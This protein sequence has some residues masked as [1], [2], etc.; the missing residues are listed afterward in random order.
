MIECLFAK[1][2]PTADEPHPL[3]IVERNWTLNQSLHVLAT[4]SDLRDDNVHCRSWLCHFSTS[5]SC[6]DDT[7]VLSKTEEDNIRV[8][9]SM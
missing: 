1:F 2:R 6:G 9:G 3:S 8:R 4:E 5:W 7:Y